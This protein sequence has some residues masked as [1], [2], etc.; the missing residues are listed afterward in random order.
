MGASMLSRGG[1]YEEIE[2]ERKERWNA[3]GKGRRIQTGLFT[4]KHVYTDAFF[5]QRCFTHRSLYVQPLLQT[6]PFSTETLSHTDTQT[7]LHTH[8][9]RFTHRRLYTRSLHT[10]TLG[11]KAFTHR[12]F[13]TQALWHTDA[14]THG[15][16]Y[17]QDDMCDVKMSRW[18][19]VKVCKWYA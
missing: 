1:A 18:E 12:R 8:T 9:H 17:T 19:D 5:R 15:S 3:G 2:R 14:F 11:Y 4:Y 10:D 16:F 13:H 7:L 6:H